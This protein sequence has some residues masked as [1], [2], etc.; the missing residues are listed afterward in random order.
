MRTAMALHFLIADTG[1]RHFLYKTKSSYDF[2]GARVE[3]YGEV[4]GQRVAATSGWFGGCLLC[5]V[6]ASKLATSHWTP[7]H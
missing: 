7:R 6:E 3:F 5:G 2:D 4:E 1:E